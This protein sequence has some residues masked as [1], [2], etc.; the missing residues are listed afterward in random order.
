MASHID[1]PEGR[2]WVVSMLKMGPMKI[3]FTKKDGTERMMN[4]T[5][6]EDLVKPYEKKTE[7]I[8]EQSKDVCPVYDIDKQSWRSFRYDSVKIVQFDL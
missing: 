3:T 2:E 4:C 7:A 6:K 1:T 5:L 8:K